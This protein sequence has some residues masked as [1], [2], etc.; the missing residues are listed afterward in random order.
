MFGQVSSPITLDADLGIALRA[1]LDQYG[2]L[3]MDLQAQGFRLSKDEFGG[4]RFVKTVGAFTVRV[5][6]SQNDHQ[7]R[8]ELS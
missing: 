6:S 1:S 7:P 2:S 8:K 4:P 3:Q 5:D